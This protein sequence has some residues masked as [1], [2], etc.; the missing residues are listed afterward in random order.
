MGISV[1]SR[2]FRQ[3]NVFANTRC[4]ERPWEVMFPLHNGNGRVDLECLLVS[5]KGCGDGLTLFS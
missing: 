4:L 3:M 5:M 2:T 1:A